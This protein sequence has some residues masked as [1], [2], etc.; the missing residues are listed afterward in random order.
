MTSDND[1]SSLKSKQE[2]KQ[3]AKA[4]Q[5]LGA[6]L[7]ALPA[8]LFD[9]LIDKFELP[10]NLH[11]ALIECRSI[12]AREANRRQLQYI[13]KL[14]RSI[15]TTSIQQLLAEIERGGQVAA[16]QLHYVE[17]WRER[18]LAAGS[19]ALTELSHHHPEA[20]TKQVQKLIERAR[21]E[22]AQKQPPRAARL[23]YKYL[24]DL[25]VV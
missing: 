1:E 9:T 4:V 14:M 5:T 10:D 7:V 24:R 13:G 12:K 23:L 25:M 15:D 21:K 17:D 2:L 6:T 3:E 16:A 18:L 8:K 11:A 19:E 20:D 22:A